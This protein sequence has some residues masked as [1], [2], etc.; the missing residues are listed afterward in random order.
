MS[1]WFQVTG[2][3]GT[4]ALASLQWFLF[5]PGRGLHDKA[6][7][8][9][10][11]PNRELSMLQEVRWKKPVLVSRAAKFHRVSALLRLGRNV[12][13]CIDGRKPFADHADGWHQIGVTANQDLTVAPVTESVVEHVNGDIH[14]GSLLFMPVEDSIAGCQAMAPTVFALHLFALEGP[15]HDVDEWPCRKRRKKCRLVSCTRPRNEGREV[16]DDLQIVVGA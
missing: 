16:S 3:V 2:T 6:A 12:D 7:G 14:V 13:G 11:N 15:Q 1:P 8:A 4:R 5:L 9:V 10:R